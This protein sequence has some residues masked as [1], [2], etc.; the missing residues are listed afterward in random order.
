VILRVVDQERIATRA[1]VR[2][3][4]RGKG[5]ETLVFETVCRRYDISGSM[6]PQVIM[7]YSKYIQGEGGAGE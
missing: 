3:K 2:R 5:Y 7:T 1:T 4:Y 6:I